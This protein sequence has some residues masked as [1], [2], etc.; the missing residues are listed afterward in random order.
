MATETNHI[1]GLDPGTGSQRW[2][3]Y[4][5]TPFDPSNIPCGDLSP[6]VGVTGTPV[7]D[8]DTGTAYFVSKTYES[9]GSGVAALYMHAVSVT[10]GAERHGFPV[11]IRGTA[12]NDPTKSFSG[13]YELQ[14]PGLLLM[15]G[16][17]YA[18]FGGHCDTGS[19]YGWVA[20]VSTSGQLRA[21]W[22]ARA[23]GSGA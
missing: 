22:V 5:G 12:Q 8:Q 2:S 21:L 18:A 7:I 19:Y 15:D 6:S 11:K 13:T 9:G 10:S 20:G 16:V 4:L 3:R 23:N 17:V 1:Y 14:R